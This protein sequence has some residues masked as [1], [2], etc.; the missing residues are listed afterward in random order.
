[1][2]KSKPIGVVV[3]EAGS[4]PAV[5]LLN[6]RQK[7]Y[8]QR[9]LNIPKNSSVH[10]ILPVSLRERGREAQPGEQPINDMDWVFE[11]RVKTL[12]KWVV[13]YLFKGTNIDQSVGVKTTELITKSEFS[14]R[15]TVPTSKEATILEARQHIRKASEL[16]FRSDGSKLDNG[17]AGAAVA[18]QT[19]A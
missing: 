18:W 12:G 10:N 15:I 4:K 11:R 1:M 3:K 6:E 8:T 16:C 5:C 9:L 17:R 13:N 2:M 19:E 14:G 7:S